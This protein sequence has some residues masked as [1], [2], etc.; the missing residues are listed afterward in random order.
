MTLFHCQY[1]PDKKCDI[2]EGDLR[3]NQTQNDTDSHSCEIG[4]VDSDVHKGCTADKTHDSGDQ[5]RDKIEADIDPGVRDAFAE[6]EDEFDQGPGGNDGV[7]QPVS[8]VIL[9]ARPGLANV[10]R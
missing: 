4:I 2:N 9:F 5:A 6:E 8:L 3:C 10:P 1:L 7:L